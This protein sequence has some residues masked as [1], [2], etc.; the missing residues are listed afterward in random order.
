MA[1]LRKNLSKSQNLPK[2]NA[3]K[4]KL[5]FL[6]PKARIAFN[7]LQLV[8]TKALIF[9]YFDFECYIK[10]KT[11]VLGYIIGRML[12]ELISEINSNRIITKTNFGQSYLIVFFFRK[13]IF[14]ET[15]YEIYNG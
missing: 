9:W 1:K 8:F 13:I 14:I 6:T 4:N 7:R 5:S 11:D 3:K 2:F 15:G 12:N 10:I